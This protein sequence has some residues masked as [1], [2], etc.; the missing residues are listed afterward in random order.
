MSMGSNDTHGW[1]PPQ[2]SAAPFGAAA[3][4]QPPAPAAWVAPRKAGLIPLRPLTLGDLLGASFR[5]LRRNPRPTLGIAMATQFGLLVISTVT[6]I[7]TMG[8]AF[9]RIASSTADNVD[10]IT[11][12]SI[13]GAVLINMLPALLAMVGVALLQGIVMIEVTRASLGEKLTL[14][15]LWRHAHGR[16]WALIGWMFIILG[17]TLAVIVVLALLIT[18]FVVFLGTVGVV[19]GVLVG[20]FGGLAFFVAAIWL[21]IKLSFVPSALMVERLRLGAAIR[22][23][24]TLSQ[25]YFWRTLGILMLIS[26]ILGLASQIILTPLSLLSPLLAFIVDPNGT[27]N[28]TGVVVIV[29]VSIVIS[30]LTVVVS[31]VISVV[32]SAAV[33]LLYIDLRMRKEGLDLELSRFVEERAAGVPTTVSDPYLPLQYGAPTPSAQAW[34]QAAAWQQQQDAQQAAAWQQQQQHAAAQQAAAPA[35]YPSAPVAPSVPPAPDF[36]APPPAPIA[37]PVSPVPPVSP[38]AP[39]PPASESPWL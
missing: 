34:Q 7:L 1:H 38:T 16:W 23:S 13:L 5:A 28:T 25:G 17:V 8:F 15:Q 6:I 19:I 24:W 35:A 36:A 2:D 12:G 20:I 31:S 10:E 33:G 4:P 39:I 22:R 3:T 32:Q 26:V 14:R 37:P 21:S 9:T 30:A 29:L 27:G 11:A 18:A